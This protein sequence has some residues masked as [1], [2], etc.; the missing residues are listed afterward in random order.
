MAF[1]IT[2]ARFTKDS[3]DATI[4]APAELIESISRLIAQ[5]GG[6]LVAHYFTFGEYDIL[7]IFEAPSHEDAM[8]ALIAAA[9][10][11]GICDLK[12]VIALPPSEMTSA[13]VKA[14]SLEAGGHFPGVSA[15]GLSSSNA[16]VEPSNIDRE[17]EGA[18][19]EDPDNA[20]AATNV[21]EARKKAVDDIQAGQ[22]APYYFAPPT[23]DPSQIALP[24]RSS[25]R[26]KNAKK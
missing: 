11:A 26:N 21:L 5:G 24:R 19:L 8:I 14:G 6:K 20:K 1:F 25:R 22:P 15:A 2:Q 9:A 18:D 23:T 17:R 12:T 4:A 10:R 7:L 13:L 16:K 3:L